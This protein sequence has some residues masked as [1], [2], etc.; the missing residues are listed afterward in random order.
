MARS[1]MA[2]LRLAALGL[3]ASLSG[4]SEDR[5]DITEPGDLAAA[6]TAT[7]SDPAQAS[8]SAFAGL[9][10]AAQA[11][12]SPAAG[13]VVYVSLPPETVPGGVRIV[14][15]NLETGFTRTEPLVDG[16]LDPV[17]VPA[18]VGHR[19]ELVV[20]LGGGAA[21]SSVARVPARRSPR[22]VRTVPPRGKTDVP[23]NARVVVVFSEPIDPR[24]LTAT[25]VQLLRGTEPVA[26]QVEFDADHL[27]AV[28]VP[29][30]PLAAATGYQLV[31]TQAIR[32]RDGEPLE[33][34]VTVGF[35]TG[36]QPLLTSY[37]PLRT[38]GRLGQNALHAPAVLVTDRSGTRLANV[39]VRFVVGP[40]GGEISDPVVITDGFG[41]AR[42][43]T[44]RLGNT[45]GENTLTVSVA[46]SLPVTFTATVVTR[47]NV[48][49]TYDLETIGGRALPLTY[50]AGSASWTITGG[51]YVIADDGTYAFGYEVDNAKRTAADIPC[52]MSQ[53]TADGSTLL[54]YLTPGSYPLSTFYH[55]RGGLFSTGT[56]S[57]NRMT[58]KYEDFIDFEDEVYVLSTASS[59]MRV[60]AP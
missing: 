40:E 58:V 57:G 59:S 41:V 38:C 44:W 31:V 23:L 11:S 3:S 12:S 35:T 28:L 22:V 32:D 39:P 34:P 30:A 24:T 53:Y 14:I 36:L 45:P 51:H 54:F 60:R 27:T 19:L 52:S 13:D 5:H 26:R 49:A 48:V 1:T 25:S 18:A 47:W 37:S 29:D 15:R 8:S 46:G 55:E 7:L 42:A 50:S 2:V 6:F 4:C 33:A 16:G 17:A 10:G 20:T 21:L 43:S 9:L 56:V